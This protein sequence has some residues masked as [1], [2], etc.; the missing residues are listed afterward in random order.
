MRRGLTILPFY[1]ENTFPMYII[2]HNVSQISGRLIL[3]IIS[4]S[5][6]HAA[7]LMVTGSGVTDSKEECWGRSEGSGRFKPKER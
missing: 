7:D 6:K 3:N 2:S 4:I 5:K 1:T